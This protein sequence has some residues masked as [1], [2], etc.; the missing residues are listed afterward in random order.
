MML[1]L[2]SAFIVP[3]ALCGCASHQL[4]VPSFE[5]ASPA[6]QG[7]NVDSLSVGGRNGAV[8]RNSAAVG[9][10]C[11]DGNLTSVEVRQNA[12]QILLSVLTL[13]LVSSA[14]IRFYCAKE[15]IDGQ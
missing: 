8:S 4:Y 9:E 3:L 5:P 2:A 12:G 1:R 15:P 13:G 11:R 10:S 6:N 14:D 7:Y